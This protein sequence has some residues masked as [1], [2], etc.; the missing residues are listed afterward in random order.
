LPIK[1]DLERVFWGFLFFAVGILLLLLSF[2]VFLISL[3]FPFDLHLLTNYLLPIA[4]LLVLAG[5]GLF[6]SGA[7]IFRLFGFMRGSEKQKVT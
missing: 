3:V 6:L 5:I 1:V 2:F 4:V 7:S